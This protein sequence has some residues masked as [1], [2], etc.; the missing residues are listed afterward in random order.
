MKSLHN[1]CFLPDGN[2]FHTTRA[3]PLRSSRRDCTGKTPSQ[4]NEIHWCAL[5]KTK[6]YKCHFSI[7]LINHFWCFPPVYAGFGVVS[8]C[9]CVLLLFS[10]MFALSGPD[11]FWGG[12]LGGNMWC[13][14]ARSSSLWV[15]HKS[16]QTNGNPI[17]APYGKIAWTAH[18]SG[19]GE[20]AEEAPATCN[21][22]NKNVC[23]SS[24]KTHALQPLAVKPCLRPVR[25]H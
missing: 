2:S 10:C 9:L 25:S 5:R 22:S 23:L 20:A 16:C 17:T 14:S 1:V 15:L 7:S 4:T 13:D 12:F 18:K 21:L 11:W 3:D 6:Q 19:F 24:A 8:V